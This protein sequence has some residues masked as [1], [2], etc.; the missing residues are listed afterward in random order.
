M[1]DFIKPF[2][3]NAAPSFSDYGKL[4]SIIQYIEIFSRTTNVSI[5]LIDYHKKG[6][7]YVSDNP[8]FLCGKTAKQ[9]QQLG[10]LFYF[11]KVPVED[12]QLLLRINSLGIEF[13][14]N[15]SI[16][17]RINYTLYYDFRLI[18][19]TR[20]TIL[21][22]H[23]LSPL[24]L[25]TNGNIWIA[26]CVVSPSS[27][28]T[29]GNFFIKNSAE[30][31]FLEFDL[32]ANKWKETTAVKLNNQEKQILLMSVQGYTIEKIAQQL[33][34][35]SSTIKFH[36]KNLFKKLKATNISEAIAAAMN[37]GAI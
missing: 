23:K 7:L 3:L 8:L 12:I 36:R 19:S 10:F 37:Y 2:H 11:K 32:A 33:F 15:L 9:V 29:S 22:N 1:N 25:D 30:N 17:E 4:G 14:K 35:S 26:L 27:N 31:T 21:V 24:V 16:K 13:F 6:F 28:L 5:Y 20:N 18:Q 34:L